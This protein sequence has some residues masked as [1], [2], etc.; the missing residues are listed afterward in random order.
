MLHKGNKNRKPV[1]QMLPLSIHSCTL[2][3]VRF[4]T[5]ILREMIKSTK[6]S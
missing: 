5:F 6:K 4:L 2:L 3:K 1:R